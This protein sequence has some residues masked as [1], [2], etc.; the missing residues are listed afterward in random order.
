MADWLPSDPAQLLGF[1]D[2][3]RYDPDVP[4]PAAVLGYDLGARLL[5]H[6]DFGALWTAWGQLAGG[7]SR[8]YGRSVEG[9]ELRQLVVSSPANLAHL[10][11]PAAHVATSGVRTG[12][13]PRAVAP[14]TA[15]REA[16]LEGMGGAESSLHEAQLHDRFDV[17][18]AGRP[19]RAPAR[20]EGLAAEERVEDVAEAEGVAGHPTPRGAARA[21]VAEE[22]VST[23]AFGIAQ[24]L[25]GHAGLLETLL[26]VGVAAAR[27]GVVAARELPVCT[28]DLV[29]GRVARDAEN[30]VVVATHERC[31][32]SCWE[33]SETAASAWR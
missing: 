6:A 5:R 4:T 12:L 3:R 17:G 21:G 7:L 19:A 15:H 28:L 16:S 20:P 25:V 1:G 30:L 27:V 32:P 26:V 18:A 14:L 9:R 23:T 8:T 11:A 2:V 24:R 22:V 10:T 33:I 13:A 29:L 31:R